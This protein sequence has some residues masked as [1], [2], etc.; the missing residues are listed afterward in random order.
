M[1]YWVY[2]DSQILGPLAKEDLGLAGGV[3]P[4]TLVCAEDDAGRLD[5]DWRCAEEVGELS[6]LCAAAPAPAPVGEDIFL[7]PGFD[8]LEQLQ[9]ETLALPR[10]EDGDGWLTDI[11]SPP[12]RSPAADAHR[13]DESTRQ[14]LR[15][16][17]T[18]SREILTQVELLSRRLAELETAPRQELEDSQT[19]V[20]E[21]AAQIELLG[22]RLAELETAPNQA[23][24]P[25]KQAAPPPPVPLPLAPPSVRA[26]APKVTAPAPSQRA[27]PPPP[28]PLPAAPPSV[29]A[30][31]PKVTAPKPED[32]KPPVPEGPALAPE[33]SPY[34]WDTQPALGGGLP[35]AGSAPPPAHKPL[36]LAATHNIP[37][38]PKGRP[39]RVVK[40]PAPQSLH[41]VEKRSPQPTP[42]GS[43]PQA[44]SAPPPAESAPPPAFAPQ[45]VLSP[46]PVPTLTPP[47]TAPGL[48]PEESPYHWGPQPTP[49][50][51]P[52]PASAPQ[53]VL[54]PPPSFSPTLQNMEAPPV[55]TLAPSAPA[56][57]A[58]PPMTMAFSGAAVL[59]PS[60][61]GA[62]VM[63]PPSAGPST[64][65]VLA[66]LAKPVPAKTAP[67]KAPKGRSKTFLIIIG[68]ASAVV[69]A[70]V[71][72]F[73]FRDSKGLKTALQMDSGRPPVGAEVSDE[74]AGAA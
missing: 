5:S 47:V 1:R 57:A 69:V 17:Q 41:T 70:A 39:R 18:R 68:S 50:G 67:P 44:E 10:E 60:A 49:D 72:F 24:A 42:G 38:A 15:Y 73:L 51:S 21:V 19:R 63:P 53:P 12:A 35:Q 2:K 55:P 36:A 32:I 59:P 45:P 16:A 26:P 7:K 37:A 14:E 54:S 66:K 65:E 29:R 52:P 71:C 4:E 20:Q 27:A 13:P 64:Q 58:L 8:L 28:V 46:P 56:P 9:F 25:I 34:H 40:V 74:S 3:R 23:P 61:A 30:P 33:Q 6:S 31:A 22:H 48:K 43:L 11:F 62:V